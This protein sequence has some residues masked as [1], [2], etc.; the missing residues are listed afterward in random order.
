MISILSIS[1]IYL[2]Y[3]WKRNWEEIYQNVLSSSFDGTITGDV[4][5]ETF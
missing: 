5:E 3:V 2:V 1:N 4:E